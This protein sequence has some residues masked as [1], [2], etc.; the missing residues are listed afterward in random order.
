MK[1]APR[2]VDESAPRAPELAP[3]APTALEAIKLPHMCFGRAMH[4]SMVLSVDASPE[5]KKKVYWDGYFEAFLDAKEQKKYVDC[6]DEDRADKDYEKNHREAVK[7]LK[8]SED[9]VEKYK[10]FFPPEKQIVDVEESFS[11]I[12][13]ARGGRR[14]VITLKDGTKTVEESQFDKS[15]H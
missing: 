10:T 6:L 3:I 4:A 12:S 7:W 15:P 9:E 1:A 8:Y 13:D 2:D 5:E 14:V 11:D